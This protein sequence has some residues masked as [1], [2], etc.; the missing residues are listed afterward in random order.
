M[1]AR[2]KVLRGQSARWGNRQWTG[3][4]LTELNNTIAQLKAEVLAE[5]RSAAGIDHGPATARFG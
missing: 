2:R 3:A 5:G 4:N 1:A